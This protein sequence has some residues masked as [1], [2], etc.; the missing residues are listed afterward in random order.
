MPTTQDERIQSSLAT[1]ANATRKSSSTLTWVEYDDDR[2]RPCAL[3]WQGKKSRP[4]QH[5]AFRSIEERDQHLAKVIDAARKVAAEKQQRRSGGHTLKV[6]DIVY[7]SWGYEQT[8]IDFYEVVSTTK[9]TVR[10]RA[11]ETQKEY[12]GDMS[13]TCTPLLG[14]YKSDDV[15]TRRASGNSVNMPHGCCSKWDGNPKGFSTYA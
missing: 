15:Q 5:L 8:N 14:V 1:R 4:T 7:N 3:I 11:V 12:D 10:L 13:G 9:C 6:G 2:G